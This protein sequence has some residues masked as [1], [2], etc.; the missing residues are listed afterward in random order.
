MARFAAADVVPVGQ[1]DAARAGCRSGPARCRDPASRRQPGTAPRVGGHVVELR[2]SAAAARTTSS[3]PLS[4]MSTPPS[5][6]AIIRFGFFGS[7]QRSWWSPCWSAL[8]VCRCVLPPSIV[9]SIGTC[10]N[11]TSSGLRRI[12][13]DRRVV[14]GALAQRV[15]RVG[16]LPGL[17]AVVGPEQPAL[18]RFDQ[19]VDAPAVGRR[20]RDADLAPDAV[21]QAVAGELLP[22]VAAVARDVEA[23]ARAAALQVPRQPPRLP[24]AGEED[25]RGSTD[26]SR[27]RTRPCRILLQD[28]LPGLAA[29]ASCDRRRARGSGRTHGRAPRRTRCRDSSGARPSCRSVPP[30]SRRASRSCRRRSI[31]RCRCRRRRCRGCWLRPIRRR[32]RSGRRR[33]GDRSDRRDRLIVEDR[34]PGRAAVGRFPHAARRGGGVVDERIARHA[35]RARHAPAG[36]GPDASILE[37]FQP[38]RALHALRFGFV[39][40]ANADEKEAETETGG[41][42]WTRHLESVTNVSMQNAKCRMQKG[43]KPGSRNLHT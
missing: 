5:L 32:R 9:C 22:G 6:A 15:R 2:R 26:P 7:I 16:Q 19:R 31:C 11:Q 23:A 17:A 1:R 14:P 27:R 18:F 34:L 43:P 25:G 20:D 10:G 12:D 40:S 42:E 38:F 28:L 21:G 41:N 33:D 35:R 3:P 30:G 29:V 36:R 4:V 8:D 39:L 13:G 37:R 24:E